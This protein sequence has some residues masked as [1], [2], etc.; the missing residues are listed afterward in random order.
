MSTGKTAKVL[1]TI[2]ENETTTTVIMDVEDER[3]SS[4]RPGQFAT[5]RIMENGE[6][7]K[8]HPFTISGAPGDKLQMTIKRNGHFTSELIP[9]L[10]DAS[11]I[12]CAGPYGIF[13]KDIALKEE[14]VMV[15]GG[16]GITPF[17]SVLRHFKKTGAKNTCTLFWCNKTFADAFAA[18]ELEE[19]AES[20]KL[21]VIHVLSR[22]TNPDMYYEEERPQIK[23]EK[24]HFSRD[25]LARH[26]HSTT[27]SF[28][29]CGPS[30]MQ[31]TVVE[32]LA[33]YGIAPDTV[34]K[35][36]FVYNG[37]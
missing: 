2:K 15:A 19:M 36:A 25:M 8:P 35:E 6:W 27:A 11:Q 9:A 34:E 29:L 23:F 18:S 7:S 30:G 1:K 14:I 26:I 3:F 21:T 37:A 16:V 24:G 31:Q 17:L 5:I 33:A 20:L 4:F 22:E 13:C 32:E 12:Q 28:Y 10:N